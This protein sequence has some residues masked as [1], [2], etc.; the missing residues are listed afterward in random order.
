MAENSGKNAGNAA[1]AGAAAAGNA[2]G[3]GGN[4]SGAAGNTGGNGGNAAS[5]KTSLFREKNLERLESPEKLNDYLRVTSPGVWMT[6]AAVI[7]LLIG[8]CIWGVFGTIQATT[9]A[10]IVTE[11][12]ESVCMVPASALEGVLEYRTVKVDGNDL[13]LQPAVLEPQIISE[14]TN[15]YVMLTGGLSVG[16][17]VY[18]ISLAEPMK[19][20]GIVPGTLVTETLSPAEL[21]FN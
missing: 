8:V 12:G 3:N 17:I 1:G 11:N 6:L 20:D 14:S 15:V 10:A 19:D 18:P 9:Q 21:F 4:A 13:E 2:G 16:D 7:V 5:K